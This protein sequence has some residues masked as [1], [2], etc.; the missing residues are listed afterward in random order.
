MGAGRF[1]SLT[2]DRIDDF[3]LDLE[4][5]VERIYEQSPQERLSLGW[6]DLYPDRS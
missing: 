1:P 4:E 6:S 2:Q 3:L 5:A